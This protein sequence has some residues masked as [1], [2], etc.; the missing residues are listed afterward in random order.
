MKIASH[1]KKKPPRKPRRF[2]SIDAH[3][4]YDL[5]PRTSVLRTHDRYLALTLVI[6]AGS[7]VIPTYSM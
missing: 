4:T 1:R 2:S 7:L 3:S 6:G 5:G